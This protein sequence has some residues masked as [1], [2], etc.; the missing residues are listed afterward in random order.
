MNNAREVTEEEAPQLYHIVE[1][2]AM[3]A[4]IPILNFLSI[5]LLI[6]KHYPLL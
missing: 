4:Q 2:M 1:D 6:S 5:V 3:V